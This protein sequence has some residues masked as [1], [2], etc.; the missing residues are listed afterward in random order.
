MLIFSFHNNLYSWKYA[1]CKSALLKVKCGVPQASFL[2][3]VLFLIISN[4]LHKFVKIKCLFYADETS[5][6]LRNKSTVKL[7]E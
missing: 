6:C 7:Q 1:R 5:M 4:D 2:G 3:P